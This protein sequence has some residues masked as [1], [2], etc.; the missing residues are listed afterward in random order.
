LTFDH[1]I[2]DYISNCLLLDSLTPV[3]S[4]ADIYIYFTKFDHFYSSKFPNYSD[5]LADYV[6]RLG[7]FFKFTAEESYY[8]VLMSTFKKLFILNYSNERLDQLDFFIL[9]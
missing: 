7:G 5:Y 1:E 4:D 9:E 2:T 3:I 6:M 8:Q